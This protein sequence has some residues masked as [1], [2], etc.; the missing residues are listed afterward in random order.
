MDTCLCNKRLL[1]KQRGDCEA[2]QINFPL[3]H[4]HLVS[5]KS[6]IQPLLSPLA[7]ADWLTYGIALFCFSSSLQSPENQTLLPVN[8]FWFLFL[9]KKALLPFCTFPSF[10]STG[11]IPWLKEKYLSDIIY[12]L[13]LC[14]QQQTATKCFVMRPPDGGNTCYC[15]WSIGFLQVKTQMLAFSTVIQKVHKGF[16]FYIG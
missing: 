15:P 2:W 5:H 12:R 9:E 1:L 4:T 16:S 6:L 8:L 14:E 7:S 11:W 3:P 13:F 10:D